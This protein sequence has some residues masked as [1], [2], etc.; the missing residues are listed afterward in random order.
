MADDLT[1]GTGNVF[2]DL[3][4]PDAA[5]RQ[6][7]TQLAMAVNGLLKARGIKQAEAARILGV[8]QPKVSALANYRLDHFSVEK[9]MC[10]LNALD[11]DVEIVIRPS[12]QGAGHTSVFALS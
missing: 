7:K 10:F 9:L 3:G 12:R 5:A 1:K 2:A 8:P 11:R 4:L 6:T